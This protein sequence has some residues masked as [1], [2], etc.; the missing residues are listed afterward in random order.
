MLDKYKAF[1]TILILFLV[2]IVVWYQ[3]N[4]QLVWKWFKDH[5]YLLS[6]L[7]IPISAMLIYTTK[8]GYEAFGALW[9]IRLIGFSVGMLSFPIITWLMLGEA[10]TFKT[11]V[12]MFLGMVIMILQLI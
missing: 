2:Q 5:P 6:L 8:I 7:G 9:P 12:C 3:L 10:V 11:A 4:G 1:L